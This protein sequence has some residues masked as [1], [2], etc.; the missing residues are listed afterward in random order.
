MKLGPV[1][2]LKKKNTS[3]KSD[4]DAMLINCD[5]IVIFPIYGQFGAI[6]KP[7]SGFRGP[8]YLTKNESRT[9][10]CLTQFSYYRFEERGYFCQK[11]NMFLKK[12]QK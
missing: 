2:K 7:D 12:M 5:V 3:K 8:F 1:T 11:N 10:K 4:N 6:R 9:R